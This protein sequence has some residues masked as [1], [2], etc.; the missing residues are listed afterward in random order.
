MFGDPYWLAAGR[1][2]SA[3]DVP[4]LAVLAEEMDSH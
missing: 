3:L 4:L 1:V 2:L